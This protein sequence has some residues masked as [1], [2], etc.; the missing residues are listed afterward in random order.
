MTMRLASR[1]RLDGASYASR[2]ASIFRDALGGYG[3]A[4]GPYALRSRQSALIRFLC[5]GHEYEQRPAPG[6]SP[7]CS[8]AVRDKPNATSAA[9]PGEADPIWPAEL[10]CPDGIVIPGAFECLHVS[11][12]RRGLE[13]S[14]RAARRRCP[15]LHR[16]ADHDSHVRTG[17]TSTKPS[18]SGLVHADSASR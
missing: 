17:C 16:C 5:F 11:T 4:R 13:V 1:T 9:C 14:L 10:R 8:W 3:R 2:R 12:K 18:L 6:A 15:T 7:G